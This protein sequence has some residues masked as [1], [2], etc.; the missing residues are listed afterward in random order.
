MRLIGIVTILHASCLA[1]TL[2][3][4]YVYVSALNVQCLLSLFVQNGWTPLMIAS[5]NGHVDVVRILIE[6]HADIHK[7]D[8]VG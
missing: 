2:A 1:F 3:L 4:H 8:K 5:F 7:Q 6:A